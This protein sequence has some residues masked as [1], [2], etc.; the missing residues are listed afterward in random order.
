MPEHPE[1]ARAGRRTSWG[2]SEQSDQRFH[3]N[4]RHTD[5]AAEGAGNCLGEF[6]G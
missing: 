3:H 2:D 5:R 6:A 4:V 1:A